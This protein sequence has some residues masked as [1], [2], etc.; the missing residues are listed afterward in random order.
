M[1]AY[2]EEVIAAV[3]AV[4]ASPV[5]F[6]SLLRAIGHNDREELGTAQLRSLSGEPPLATWFS[7]DEDE[8]RPWPTGGLD[9]GVAGLVYALSS[10]GCPT[11]ASCRGHPGQRAWSSFPIVRFAARRWRAVRLLELAREANCGL[12]YEPNLLTLWARSV[13]DCLALGQLIV[14]NKHTF[15]QAPRR[16]RPSGQLR[17]DL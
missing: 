5:E 4:A 17:L 1:L 12:I 14:E 7:G 8:D 15:R 9:I 2:E 10:V 11:T 13:L 6:D 3:G 16:R